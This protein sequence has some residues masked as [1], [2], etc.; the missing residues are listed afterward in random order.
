M[1]FVK[2][3]G[4]PLASCQFK[5]RHKYNLVVHI[6]GTHNSTRQRISDAK[7]FNFA[8]DE[9]IKFKDD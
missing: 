7:D 8:L 6:P 3:T 4:K 2:K 5:S 9:L 1:M